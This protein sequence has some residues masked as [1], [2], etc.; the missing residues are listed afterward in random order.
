MTKILILNGAQPYEF[1]PGS[2]N[3]KLFVMAPLASVDTHLDRLFAEAGH[4]A[5]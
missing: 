2:V 4:V 3:A 1:D 5:A